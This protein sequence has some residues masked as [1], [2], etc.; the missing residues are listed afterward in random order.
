MKT[1][2][3]K[4]PTILKKYNWNKN[5]IKTLNYVFEGFKTA[6]KQMDILVNHPNIIY[7]FCSRYF[8][9]MIDEYFLVL[10]NFCISLMLNY[11]S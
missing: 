10:K 2:T 1:R 9:S 8:R 4:S 7:S 5:L 6:L 11:L 3:S